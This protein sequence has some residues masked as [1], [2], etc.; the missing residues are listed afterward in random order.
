[1][2]STHLRRPLGLLLLLSLLLVGGCGKKGAL[3][4]PDDPQHK[5]APSQPAPSN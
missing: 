1:M 5:P 4:H 2:I 3:Y